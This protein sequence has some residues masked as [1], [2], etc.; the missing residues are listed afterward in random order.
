[1]SGARPCAV[2]FRETGMRAFAK[3]AT[4]RLVAAGLLCW[5]AQ[6]FAQAPEGDTAAQLSLSLEAAIALAVRNNRELVNAQLGRVS[7]RFS[8][9]VAENKF[10]PHITVGSRFGPVNKLHQPG[11]F[12]DQAV[13]LVRK[14]AGHLHGTCSPP[15]VM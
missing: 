7:E 4:S 6:G 11:P 8:L 13:H 2:V 9:R 5:V 14:I 15:T 12:E 3:K 1:M 10:R